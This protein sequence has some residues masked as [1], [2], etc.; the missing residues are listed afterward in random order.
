MKPSELI[1]NADQSIYHLHLHPEQVAPLII[2]V[3]D[4]DRVAKVS[5]YFDKVEF[6]VRKREFVTHT[7]WLGKTRLSVIST[8]IGPDNID[9]VLNELDALFNVDLKTKEVKPDIT[10]LTFIRLGTAG[11]LQREIPVDALVASIGGLGMDGLLQYYHAPEQQD[12]PLVHALRKHCLNDWHFP[13]APYYASGDPD[14][15]ARFSHNFYTGITATNPGFY[16]PQGRQLRASVRQ[17]RYLDLLQTFEFEGNKIVNLEMETAALYGLSNLLGHRAIS[18]SA[19]LANRAEG[20]F[21]R[22]PARSVRHLLETA[23]ESIA[24]GI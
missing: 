15:M 6:R 14:L 22:N 21:S 19:I 12:H 8:G 3:G 11:G 17:P 9:I 7:G 1:L 4:Q 24:A 5:A 20:T 18:L 13:L 16:G 10:P 2:T 23:L